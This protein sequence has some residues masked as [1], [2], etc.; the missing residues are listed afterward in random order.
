MDYNATFGEVS[1]AKG[2]V[3]LFREVTRG[4]ERQRP[5][6]FITW[7]GRLRVW[8]TIHASGLPPRNAANRFPEP[9]RFSFLNPFWALSNGF[10]TV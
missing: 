10:F 4:C 5:L 7:D 1:W 8:A 3:R 9:A 2:S 6:S